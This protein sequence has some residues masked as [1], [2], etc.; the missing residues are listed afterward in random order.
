MN[1]NWPLTQPQWRTQEFFPGGWGGSVSANSVEDRGQIKRG[2]GGGS[3]YSRVPLNLQMG[4]NPYSYYVVADVFS[5]DLGIRL[6]FVNTSEFRGGVGFELPKPPPRYATAQTAIRCV[7]EVPYSGSKE[8]G[9]AVHNKPSCSVSVQYS[10]KTCW[11]WH[12]LCSFSFV[13][14][15]LCA[16]LMRQFLRQRGEADGINVGALTQQVLEPAFGPTSFF[17]L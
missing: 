8:E 4:W 7:S 10:H 16:V 1:L 9:R 17:V 5:T 3:P 6:S 14:A 15:C 11:R 12:L 13:H 2:S